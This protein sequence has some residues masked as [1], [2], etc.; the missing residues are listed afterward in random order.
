MGS[1]AKSDLK[2]VLGAK[3][4]FDKNFSTTITYYSKYNFW[5]DVRVRTFAMWFIAISTFMVSV[6]SVVV[7]KQNMRLKQELT[8]RYQQAAKI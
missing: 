2:N 6:A 5:D 1:M 7:A 8:K 4:N 3:R